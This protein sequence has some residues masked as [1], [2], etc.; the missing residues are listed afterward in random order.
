MI[1][2]IEFENAAE[3]MRQDLFLALPKMIEYKKSIQTKVLDIA[4]QEELL[5]VVAC[6]T[7]HGLI[8]KLIHLA[9]KEWINEGDAASLYCVAMAVGTIIKE[10]DWG[11]YYISP[12]GL[13]ELATRIQNT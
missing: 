4:T 13:Y 7:N 9:H 2:K 10:F 3:A 1:T 6:K 5:Y 12:E 8:D 11:T